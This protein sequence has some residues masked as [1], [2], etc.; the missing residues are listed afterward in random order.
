MLSSGFRERLSLKYKVGFSKGNDVTEPRYLVM[1][2]MLDKRGPEDK[3]FPSWAVAPAC[4][5]AF[6]LGTREDTAPPP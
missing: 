6:F 3:A 1:R 2:S 4:A 5:V